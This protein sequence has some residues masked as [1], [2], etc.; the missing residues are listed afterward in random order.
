M[1]EDTQGTRFETA[2]VLA[3][4]RQY[5]LCRARDRTTGRS[6]LL[7]ILREQFV[8]TADISWLE[9]EYAVLVGLHR[10]DGTAGQRPENVVRPLD[11][12]QVDGC[13]ALLMED[14][15]GLPLTTVLRPGGAGIMEA[16]SLAVRLARTLGQIHA[17][18][19][20]HLQVCPSSILLNPG[21]GRFNLIDFRLATELSQEGV[22]EKKRTIDDI[23]GTLPKTNDSCS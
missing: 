20:V 16:T 4:T 9:H 13:P 18:N 3:D 14:I 10:S 11:M 7:K 17:A 1:T 6:Y 19:L 22:A 8:T 5:R 2:E 23:D 12:T 21:D 15:G